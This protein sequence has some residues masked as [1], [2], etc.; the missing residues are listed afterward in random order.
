MKKIKLKFTLLFILL[1]VIFPASRAASLT[2]VCDTGACF[3]AEM[4]KLMTDPSAASYTS[5]TVKGDYNG[6]YWNELHNIN[7]VVNIGI[8]CHS[9]TYLRLDFMASYGGWNESA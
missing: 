5:L 9:L 8:R 1:T 4:D 7:K 2:I 3:D 6:Y